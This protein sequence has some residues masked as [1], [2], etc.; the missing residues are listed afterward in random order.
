VGINRVM[1]DSLDLE[2]RRLALTIEHEAI[3]VCEDLARRL[4]VIVILIGFSARDFGPCIGS[5]DDFP[6]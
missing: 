3:G 1:I 2:V 5:I 6:T 4:D